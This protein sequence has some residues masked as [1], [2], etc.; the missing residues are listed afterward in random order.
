MGFSGIKHPCFC[1]DSLL[2]GQ[3]ARNED[4]HWKKVIGHDKLPHGTFLEAVAWHLLHI[5]V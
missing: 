4:Q 3:H 2:S 5:T 1:S